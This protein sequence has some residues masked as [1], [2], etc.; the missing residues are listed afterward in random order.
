MT[1]AS[2]PASPPVCTVAVPPCTIPEH[3]RSL[4]Q[5]KAK[6]TLPSILPLGTKRAPPPSCKQHDRAPT[7]PGSKKSASCNLPQHPLSPTHSTLR[8][9]T[10]PRI[11]LVLPPLVASR[12]TAEWQGATSPTREKSV[13]GNAVR[14]MDPMGGL[15]RGEGR[16]EA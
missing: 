1:T 12:A 2:Q 4:E 9:C 16:R 6:G 14:R 15:E 8:C 3:H 7:H 13:A 10:R 11:D 5:R